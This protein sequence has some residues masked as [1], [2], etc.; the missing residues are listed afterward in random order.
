[1]LPQAKRMNVYPNNLKSGHFGC[2]KAL[3]FDCPNAHFSDCLGIE[4][5]IH[6]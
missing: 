3:G 4:E 5:R 2:A 6:G 1:M